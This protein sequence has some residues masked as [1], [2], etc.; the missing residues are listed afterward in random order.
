MDAQTNEKVALFRYQVILPLLEGALSSE[1][2]RRTKREI[3]ETE[4]QFPDGTST[5]LQ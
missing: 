3:L 4:W 5:D 2:E 1:D